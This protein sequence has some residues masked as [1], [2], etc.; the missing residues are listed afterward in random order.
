[1]AE[2]CRRR[3]PAAHVSVGDMRT[4]AQQISGPFDAILAVDNILDVLEP[5]DRALVLRAVAGLLAPDGVLIF[6]A[7]NRDNAPGDRVA[8]GGDRV[9]SG[10]LRQLAH[11]SAAQLLLG[12]RGSLR[13]TINRRRLEPA[14]VIT[15]EYAVLNDPEADWAAL[16]YYVT[17]EAQAGQLAAAGLRMTEC[18]DVDGQP[19]GAGA[20]AASPWLHYVARRADPA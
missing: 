16:H 10:G 6:S 12:A 19:G 8:A 1:M 3:Y 14:Q 7:H 18:L 15:S 11:R 2:Y 4:V 13:G 5:D 20:G 17:A 9:G